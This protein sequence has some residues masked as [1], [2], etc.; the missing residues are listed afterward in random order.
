MVEV[1]PLAA[2]FVAFGLARP[3]RWSR[4]FAVA[5]GA[6]SALAA[7]LMAAMPTRALNTAFE[8]KIRGLFDAVLGMDPLGWLPSFQPVTPDWYVAAY[9]RL[10]PAL[11]LTAALAWWGWRRR[12]A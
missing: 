12:T 10:V 8:E 5:A 6:T 9:L 1:V 4:A 2:P 3:D 11:L 7:L